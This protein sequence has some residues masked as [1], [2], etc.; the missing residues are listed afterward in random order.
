MVKYSDT[1]RWNDKKHL[2]LVILLLKLYGSSS[3]TE[4]FAHTQSFIFFLTVSAN[5]TEQ[6]LPTESCV[7]PGLKEESRGVWHGSLISSLQVGKQLFSM[8]HSIRLSHIQ[9]FLKVHDI[10]N[11]FIAPHNIVLHIRHLVFQTGGQTRQKSEADGQKKPT[12]L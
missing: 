5:E 6:E 9:E 4:H 1:C 12:T 8:E 3:D 7:Q 2:P 11:L 10:Q